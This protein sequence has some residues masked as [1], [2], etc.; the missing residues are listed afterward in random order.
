MKLNKH[1]ATALKDINLAIEWSTQEKTDAE[2]VFW[3]EHMY[4]LGV[5]EE[6]LKNED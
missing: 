5:M 1:I 4:W 2:I 6:K 3:L